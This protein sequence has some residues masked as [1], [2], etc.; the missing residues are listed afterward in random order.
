ML[1]NFGSFL[2]RKIDLENRVFK[3]SAVFKIGHSDTSA[4]P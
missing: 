3:Y 1:K 4:R 2:V